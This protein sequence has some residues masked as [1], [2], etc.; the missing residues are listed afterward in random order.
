MKRALN[1]IENIKID[2]KPCKVA[3]YGWLNFSINIGDKT[4]HVSAS[5]V[6]DP[7]YDLLSWL[8][9]IAQGYKRYVF[10]INEEKTYVEFDFISFCEVDMLRI[11]DT[12]K[13]GLVIETCVD[14]Y[15][16]VR[17]FYTSFLK[18]YR[19]DN[20]NKEKNEIYYLYEK[21]E[22]NMNTS[23]L[24]YFKS[25]LTYMLSLNKKDLSYLFLYFYFEKITCNNDYY[26]TNFKHF[27]QYA[28]QNRK[29]YKIDIENWYFKDFD[30][31]TYFE[32]I[33]TLNDVLHKECNTTCGFRLKNF[34]SETLEDYIF[35]NRKK[36][37]DY[38]HNI[39][40]DYEIIDELYDKEYLGQLK[41]NVYVDDIQ[42]LERYYLDLNALYFCTKENGEH[43]LFTCS[44]GVEEC[45]G[46]WKTPYTKISDNELIWH[47]YEPKNYIF[48]F[49]KAQVEDALADLE[50]RMRKDKSMEEWKKIELGLTG[51]VSEF[52]GA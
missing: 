6:Y 24:F 21:I 32:K 20:Y 43:R 3:Q 5:C 9:K 33:E 11:K 45:G 18:F 26:E 16:L 31:K 22:D 40:F 30:K 41:V 44:C 51:N 39:Y 10:T 1:K 23:A 35:K 27:I 7:F 50:K 38:Y 25:T 52:L 36:R 19:S 14:K 49:E 47:I 29:K 42:I 12:G 28:K 13:S 34:K 15:Q 48:V 4:I 2:I 46:I 37:E 17:E 8:E